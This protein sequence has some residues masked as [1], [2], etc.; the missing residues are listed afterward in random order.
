MRVLVCGDRNWS[1]YEDIRNV[2]R[3][4]DKDTVVIHG[5]CRGADKIAGVMAKSLGLK[6]KVYKANWGKYKKAAGPIRNTQMLKEGKPD[7]VLAF[8]SYIEGSTG[9]AD[10]ID[11]ST[12]AGVFT[13]LYE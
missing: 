3:Q 4:F 12:D 6:V 10:M 5:N 1:D 2:L 7:V 13:I 11:Q 9:T 8:H